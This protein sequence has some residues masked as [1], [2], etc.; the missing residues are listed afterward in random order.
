MIKRK[1][2]ITTI[3]FAFTLLLII[4][5]TTMSASEDIDVWNTK[6]ITNNKKVWTIA[7]ND[8]LK[9]SSINKKTVYVED[10]HYRFV[11][12]DVA[13]SSDKKS[14]IV[15]PKDFYQDNK[16]YRL[17]IS[18]AVSS[19][20]GKKLENDIVLPFILNGTTENVDPDIGKEAIT[21]VTITPSAY[22]SRITA[23]SNDM[24]NKVTANGTEM[25]YEGN[26]TYSLGMIGLSSD[27]NVRI[28][29]YDLKG[30]ILF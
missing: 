18:K 13:L 14:I 5:I 2:R 12:T 23:I 19:E 4:P 26:N 16:T 15:T 11:F 30:K 25:H 3:L 28:V 29:A 7:F 6:T 22:A 1:W 10:D 8:P 24:V 20:K 27:K 17:Y 21:S 9:E